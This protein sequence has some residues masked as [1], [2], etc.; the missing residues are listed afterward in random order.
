MSILRGPFA[1]WRIGREFGRIG[2]GGQSFTDWSDTENASKDALLFV[3][4]EN[5]ARAYVRHDRR[6]RYFLRAQRR[7]K[8]IMGLK[9]F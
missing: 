7:N 4:A 3:H 5:Q 8:G 6:R 9:S 2:D 1:N